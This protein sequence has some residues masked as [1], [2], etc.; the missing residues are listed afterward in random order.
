MHNT[1]PVLL[2]DDE[3]VVAVTTEKQREQFLKQLNDEEE[4]LY[5]AGE[6]APATEHQY[7]LNTII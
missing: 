1:T 2:Q 7:V 6:D 3:S 4:W 5:D